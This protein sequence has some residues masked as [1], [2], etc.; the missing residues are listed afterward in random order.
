MVISWKT[1]IFQIQYRDK[2]GQNHFYKN[3]LVPVTAAAKSSNAVEYHMPHINVCP[4]SPTVTPFPSVCPPTAGLFTII[5]IIHWYSLLHPTYTPN[6]VI[7]FMAWT[8]HLKAGNHY[9]PTEQCWSLRLSVTLAGN[10]IV[11]YHHCW[12]KNNYPV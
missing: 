11:S 4:P 8:T 7:L 1:T 6:P 12:M 10:I 3:M 2:K 9:P 5:V